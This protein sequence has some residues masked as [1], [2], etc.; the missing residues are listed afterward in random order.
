MFFVE[1]PLFTMFDDDGDAVP[2]V[3][4]KWL[5]VDDTF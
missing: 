1:F 3:S 5:Y 4:L 2:R